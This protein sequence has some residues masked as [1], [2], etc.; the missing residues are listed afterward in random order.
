MFKKLSHSLIIILS[1]LILTNAASAT[2]VSVGGSTS[3]SKAPLGRLKNIFYNTPSYNSITD[4]TTLTQ[5]MSQIINVF[6]GLLGT[7]FI[8]LMVYAGYTWMTAA[9]E[10][11]KVKTAGHIIKV[12]I[13]GL[14]VTVGSYAIWQFL[15]V[16][17]LST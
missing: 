15:F 1:F 14:I 3:P 10:A 9:G 6:F 5:Y 13:I 17:L 16:R 2:V 7:I 12:A 4:E 11:D 8:F